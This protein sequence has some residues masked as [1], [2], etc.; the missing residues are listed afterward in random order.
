VGWP[1]D[2]SG[3][4]MP[5]VPKTQVSVTP[6]LTMPL[7]RDFAVTT[8]VDVLYRSSFYLD[9]D[10]DPK[11]LQDGYVKLNGR[12]WV[13]PRDEKWAIALAVD[14]LTNVDA[15][16]FATD[17]LVFPHAFTAFQE[18]Q[19]RYRWK[20]AT[21]GDAA[22]PPVPERRLRRFARPDARAYDRQ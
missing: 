12:I 14:N 21:T 9:N 8:A 18:F 7:P 20:P 11:T 5:F 2:L 22:A 4:R 17:S 15:L 3:K 19:R 16:E 13:G 10:L 6:E 1:K